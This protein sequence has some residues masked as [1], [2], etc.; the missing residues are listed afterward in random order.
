MGKKEAMAAQKA[1]QDLSIE[2]IK[3]LKKLPPAAIQDEIRYLQPKL[4][5]KLFLQVGVEQHELDLNID[6]LDME[7]DEDYKNMVQ[8]YYEV[9]ELLQKS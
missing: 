4:Y 2:Q 1:L 6:K 8:E 3:E 7:N 9:V 5:D